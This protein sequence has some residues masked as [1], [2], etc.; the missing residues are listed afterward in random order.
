MFDLPRT[1]VL[2]DCT[3]QALG[4][5]SADLCRWKIKLAHFNSDFNSDNNH[6]KLVR[7]K[8]CYHQLLEKKISVGKFK[9]K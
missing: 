3:A 4:V 1:I 5:T 8:L 9:C 7:S 2:F 6:A